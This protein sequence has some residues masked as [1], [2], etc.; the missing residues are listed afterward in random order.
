MA[1]DE[2]RRRMNDDVGTVL[3]RTDLYR[4][5]EGV[6]DDERE[7]MLVS[8]LYPLVEVKDLTVRV[9]EGLG[10]EGLRVRLDGCLYL[11]VVVRI[12]ERGRYAVVG[13]GMGEVVVGSTVDVLRGNDVV[14]GMRNG[15]KCVSNGGCTR[16][17]TEGGDTTLEGGHSLL[18]DILGRVRQSRIDISCILQCE[19]CSCMVRIVKHEC[20]GLV[21]RDGSRAGRWIRVLLSYVDGLG[22]KSVISVYIWL[23]RHD[24]LLLQLRLR[25]PICEAP[26]LSS[27]IQAASA[28]R[29]GV[30][31][32]MFSSLRSSVS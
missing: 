2:L 12:Y 9:T 28:V 5:C 4:G 21:D 22:V 16:C 7:V 8:D 6:I 29:I 25:V 15:L 31:V 32:P 24:V 30:F 11:L 13:K 20:A 18:E 1:A 10:I 14:T 23:L 3:D 19:T 26:E 27:M 17:N